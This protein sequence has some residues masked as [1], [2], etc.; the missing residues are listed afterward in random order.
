MVKVLIIDDSPLIRRL[1]SE[2]LSQASDIEV[3]GCAEDPYQAREMIKLLNPDV[4]TLDVEMPKMDGISFLRNLMR[5]RPMPVVMI[6]TLTQQGSPITL[7]ALE[8]G[9][10]D[11]IAKPT[12]NVKQQMSQYAYVVQQKVRVAA[13]ARVRSFKKVSTVSEPL[14][15]NA[16]FLLNKVIA[17]GA[18]T[19]GTEAI[20][21]VLIKMPTNCPAIVITQH[22]PPVFSTSF[23]QRMDRTC[24]INVKEAQHGDKLTAGW[25]Y[26]APGGLHLSIKKRGA[27]LYC[28]LDDSEPVNRHKPAVDVL[29]NSLLECG[30]KNIVAALLTGMGSDGAKG[31]LSIKQAGGYTIAQDEFS[32]VVW[33]MPKAAVDLGA[34]HEIVALDKVTQRLLHQTI[35]V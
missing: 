30:A 5:L 13:G 2:I 21:E 16:Q 34:A 8:L 17:I 14:P 12:V 28:E 24:A 31:L 22:I 18:S 3:V 10:V 26:I 15:S 20:K 32:S 19:G 35:K 6:S 27:S 1:L 4:L 11:F 7:E 9:A 33:G 25:A 23:A 29:F